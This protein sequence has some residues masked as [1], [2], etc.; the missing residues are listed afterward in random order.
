MTARV[1]A[2]LFDIDDTVCEY[3]R[4]GGDILP[5]AFE[6]V[7]VEPFFSVEE[8][9]ARY[10]DFLDDSDSVRDLRERCFAALARDRGRDPETGRAVARAFADERD[11]TA[12]RFRPGARETLDALHGELPLA[13]VTNG[14]P[15]M[16]SQK[17]D[18]LGV[19]HFETVV[20]AGYD[21]PAKPAAEP[22]Y[23]ALDAL[24]VP[25]ER[26]VHVGNSLSSDVAGARAAG[27][28]AVWLRE[29][30]PVVDPEPDYVLDSVDELLG[31]S[32]PL[33]RPSP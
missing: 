8:Y 33:A 20:H 5:I 22:F 21:T 15:G 4:T 1:E 29:E 19:D 11:H 13:A 26:T 30:T 9:V 17:L 27:V 18:A 12:V 28:G 32:G 24:G 6:R 7:G 16:Q 31:E 25:P 3:R 23:H 14:S 10:S 2:V